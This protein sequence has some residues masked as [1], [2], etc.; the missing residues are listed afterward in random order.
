MRFSLLASRITRISS[1]NSPAPKLFSTATARMS[2]NYT[3]KPTGSGGM[4]G[5]T[6]TPA[7]SGVGVHKPKALDA[8][9][10]I[11]KQFNGKS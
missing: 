1:V 5:A 6:S 3:A 11:G 8:D 9:G 10:A 7:N 4:S 2:E